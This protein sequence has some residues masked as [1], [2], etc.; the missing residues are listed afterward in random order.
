MGA[1]LVF[2]LT[3]RDT[4][5]STGRWLKE[6]REAARPKITVVL[7]G[8]KTDLELKRQVSTDEANAYAEEN[9]M[10]YFE[11]SSKTGENITE[12]LGACFLEIEKKLD[13]GEISL[14]PKIEP[15]T[16][17]ATAKESGPCNC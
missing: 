12:A 17:N 5:T 13:S 10:V 8:N 11:T 3:S 2:A 9:G 1:L 15:P 14:A 16:F 7:I 4:F 6:L